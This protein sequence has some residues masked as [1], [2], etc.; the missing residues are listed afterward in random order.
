M[1]RYDRVRTKNKSYTPIIAGNRYAYVD[2]QME[3][4]EALHPDAHVFFNHGPV[5]NEPDVNAVIT[6]QLSLKAGLNKWDKK[7]RG[8]VH[9]EM[10]H[11][12]MRD[13]SIPLH[14]Q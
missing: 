12:H 13:T 2:A 9:S 10:K 6:P 5:Q 14:R 7:D 3:E 8:S 4:H 11:I 1:R